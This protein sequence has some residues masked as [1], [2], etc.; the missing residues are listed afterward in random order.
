MILKDLCTF[1]ENKAPLSLQEE[2]DNSGLLLGDPATEVSGALLC[3][4]IT[5]EV[6]DEAIGKGCNLIIS[7]HPMVFK[8][9]KK[10]VHGTS[11]TKL[12][13]KAIK[14][15]LAIYS[16]H[17]NLDNCLEG[18]NGLLMKKI[19][20]KDYQ[21]IRS[22]RGKLIKLVTFCP[23]EYA[24]R[25]RLVL[26]EAGAGVIGKYDSC[27]FNASGQ[28]TFR[29]SENT[30][31]FVGK[32]NVLHF[33]NEVRI[34]VILPNYL[35]N[36]VVSSLLQNHPYEEVAYDLYPLEN[37]YPETGSGAFGELSRKQSGE[38]FLS[39]LKS[40]L[41]LKIIRHSKLGPDPIKHIGIC[42][43]SGNFLIGEA[44]SAK[45]D[46]FVTSDLK[47]HDFFSA[48]D[49][50]LLVDIG[51]YESEHWVKEWIHDMLIEKFPTF[52]CLISQ[53]NTNPIYY[54]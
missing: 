54:F 12:L 17:T 2:Y 6:M 18:L 23:T 44:V 13:C 25:I 52:A 4:D 16:I 47:Y 40:S 43:G 28:G 53:V 45:L 15:E 39:H 34:E 3:L 1:L 41:G 35:R 36:Q 49:H 30:N 14:N 21:V 42:T 24:E 22:S 51:H 20:I 10:L 33:E 29:A 48:G 11:E 32:K 9:L 37:D 7:H 31:P 19:G 27:S 26:F 5:E 46:V 8:G 38:G 50:L